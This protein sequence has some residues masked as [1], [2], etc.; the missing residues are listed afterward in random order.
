MSAQRAT[1]DGRFWTV[2]TPKETE[3]PGGDASCPWPHTGRGR[4][5]RLDLDEQAG[6][7]EDDAAEQGAGRVV[8]AALRAEA[9]FATAGR[10][11]PGT[12]PGA[13]TFPAWSSGHAPAANTNSLA[14]TAA[15]EA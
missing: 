5:D 12:S 10:A 6:V 11:C 4:R 7:A 2:P 15:T 3:G 1:S 13:T 8:L 9:R 14:G